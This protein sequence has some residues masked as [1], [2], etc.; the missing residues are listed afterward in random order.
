LVWAKKP[1]TKPLGLGFADLPLISS[2]TASPL[3][4]LGGGDAVGA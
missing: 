4:R 1:K 2:T 3:H